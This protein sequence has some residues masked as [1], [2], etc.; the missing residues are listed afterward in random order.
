MLFVY[1]YNRNDYKYF[2][3]GFWKFI[4]GSGNLNKAIAYGMRS[5]FFMSSKFRESGVGNR[6]SVE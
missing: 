1:I 3:Q 2:C 4:F 6:E 5:R